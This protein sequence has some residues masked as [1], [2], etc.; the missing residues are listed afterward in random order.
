MKK[1]RLY[2]LGL[3]EAA[4]LIRSGDITAEELAAAL[5][6]RVAAREKDVRAWVWFDADRLLAA[7]RASDARHAGRG[8][9]DDPR[10]AL[11]ADERGLL[12]GVPVAVKDIV[13][14]AGMPT[15]MGSPVYADNWP[16]RSAALVD[17]LTRSGAIPMGKTVTTEFAFMVPA[18]TRNPWNPAHTPGG[19]SSGSAAAVAC[20]MAPAAI[21]TQ[22]NGSVIRPA[23]FCGVVGFKPGRGQIALDGVLPFSGTL[24]QPGVIARSVDDAALAAS[25]L[26]RREGAI[27]HRVVSLKTAPRLLAVR[28]PVWERATSVQRERLSADV[29][30]LRRGGAEVDERELPDH[31]AEAYGIHRTIMLHEAARGARALRKRHRALFSDYLNAALDEGERIGVREYRAAVRACGTFITEFSRF[32]TDRYD[33]IVTP[34]A[35]GEA[36]AGLDGTG[37]P[38]FCTLWTL[39]GVP[40]ITIPTALGPGGLPLGLQ[41]VARPGEC[42]ALL[43]VAAWCEARLPFRNR[44][45][46]A[47]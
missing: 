30:T 29:A 34:P 24:D 13:D 25:W 11:S 41:I 38:A 17:A 37:D 36:P 32:L 3:R 22:T 2:R 19:S 27:G 23:A 28:S 6:E 42:N 47:R 39:L 15:G 44:L 45:L 40:A 14:V 8:R 33:A 26:T 16:R 1:A 12:T 10:D 5:I 31:F 7:A 20:G 46:N 21:A 35:P 43:A 18:G 4:N 9:S